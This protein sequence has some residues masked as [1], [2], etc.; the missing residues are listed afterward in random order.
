MEMLEMHVIAM[1]F[2]VFVAIIAMFN[3]WSRKYTKPRRSDAKYK[4]YAC[5]EDMSPGKLNVPQESFY[6]VMIRSLKLEKLRDWH[7]GSLTRYLI[8][9]FTG[10][11]LVMLYLLILW[12]M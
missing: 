6:M 8:W 9:V 7:S 10:M 4:I 12:G 2:L 1:A 11:V 3:R 5:G